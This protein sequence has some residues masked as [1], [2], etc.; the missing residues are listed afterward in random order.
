MV[1][2]YSGSL[3]YSL[4]YLVVNIDTGEIV[5]KIDV[6]HHRGGILG[7]IKTNNMIFTIG[8]DLY[9]KYACIS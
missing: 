4:K 6:Y 1:S 2:I 8:R 7:I 5:K 9:L 3:D